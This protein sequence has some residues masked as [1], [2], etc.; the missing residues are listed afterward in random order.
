MYDVSD[1]IDR[2]VA[3]LKLQD[4]GVSLDNLTTKQQQYLN[5]YELK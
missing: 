5:G 3:A 1:E 2:E 4:M